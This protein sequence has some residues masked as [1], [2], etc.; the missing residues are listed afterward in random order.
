MTTTSN[1]LASEAIQL[2]ADVRTSDVAAIRTIVA[3]TNMF[4][5]AE[6]DIA[7]ELAQD[8]ADKGNASDYSFLI[9]EREGKVVGYAC[10]GPIACTL[11]S[12]DLYW[13]AVE[14]DCQGT[15][16]GK[17]LLA[18]TEAAVREVGGTRIYI[19]TAGRDAYIPTRKF[20]ESQQ[21]ARVATLPDF[22]APDDAKVIYSKTLA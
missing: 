9:A 3:Q 22:Y 10:Y 13:I 11:A 15:G 4:T 8:A 18:A 6:V 7:A 14:P 20:Y 16:L 19:D 21:Y 1:K 2:R 17:K 5:P 12:F